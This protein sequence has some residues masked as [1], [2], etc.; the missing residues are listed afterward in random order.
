MS[1]EFI[2]LEPMRTW[3]VVDDSTKQAKTLQCYICGAYCNHQSFKAIYYPNG[4]NGEA[5]KT[6]YYC[7]KDAMS[8]F[9]YYF[10][11]ELK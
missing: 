8:K 2:F 6:E 7:R 4:W 1:K 11:K 9:P 3:I 10:K 5:S